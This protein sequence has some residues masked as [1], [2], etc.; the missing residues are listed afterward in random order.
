MYIFQYYFFFLEMN[1]GFPEIKKKKSG[2]LLAPPSGRFCP[3]AII[4]SVT[5]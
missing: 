2:A 4:P 1:I 3:P 5:T